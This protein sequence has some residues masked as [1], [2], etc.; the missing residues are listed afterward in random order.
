[1][2]IPS[3]YT[4]DGLSG[5]GFTLR[6]GVSNKI[7]KDGI[8]L[9]LLGVP[10]QYCDREPVVNAFPTVFDPESKSVWEQCLRDYPPKRVTS[11]R[12]V[13][14][15]WETTLEKFQSL[16]TMY[17]TP[18]FKAT[19]I[20]KVDFLA[21]ALRKQRQRL[22]RVVDNLGLFT[23][24][25]LQIRDTDLKFVRS[26]D[27]TSISCVAHLYWTPHKK[28]ELEAY[29]S[30]LSGIYRFQRQVDRRYVCRVFPGLY[31]WIL[32]VNQSQVSIGFVV[33]TRNTLSLD[34]ISNLEIQTVNRS[35]KFPLL[36]E[37]DKF[38]MT[39]VWIPIIRSFKFR[40]VT[41]RLF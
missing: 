28:T 40:N 17:G 20:Q 38:L 1:M 8:D 25:G 30:G 35:W 32:F 15:E 5:P 24:W 7:G 10:T 26:D 23:D 37:T 29:I 18:W 14:R 6:Q 4:L 11:P 13:Q 31:L 21:M 39:E 9:S 41:T 36:S 27:G 3:D 19:S 16:C 33:I 34:D 22:V 2:T 12:E